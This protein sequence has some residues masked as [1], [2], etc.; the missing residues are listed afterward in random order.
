VNWRGWPAPEHGW[1][2][3]LGFPCAWMKVKVLELINISFL[4]KF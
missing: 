2:F 3:F 4:M 1:F